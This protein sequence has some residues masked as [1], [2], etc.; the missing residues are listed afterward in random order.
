VISTCPRCQKPVSIPTGVDPTTLVRCPLCEA[1]YALGEALAET[2]PELIPVAL[3]I[4]DQA[5]TGGHEHAA[6]M[7]FGDA[8]HELAA[9]NEAV[10]AAR[11]CAA[12]PTTGKRRRRKERSP[13]RT[14]IDVVSGGL[15]GCLLAYYGLAFWFGPE[16]RNLGFPVLPLPGIVQITAPKDAGPAPAKPPEK[17]PADKS[18]QA[19]AERGPTSNALAVGPETAYSWS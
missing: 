7:G 3:R 11:E 6:A 12:R 1:E 16:F 2:P 10:A 8:S 15:A 4:A 9:E 5:T 19:A 14:L 18:P 13:L 17:K